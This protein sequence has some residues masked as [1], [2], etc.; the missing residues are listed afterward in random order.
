MPAAG[1]VGT[2]GGEV[3]SC[4]ARGGSRQDWIPSGTQLNGLNDS[5]FDVLDLRQLSSSRVGSGSGPLPA[6]LM[7]GGLLNSVN[8]ARARACRPTVEA[9]WSGRSPEYYLVNSLY[10]LSQIQSATLLQLDTQ[11]RLGAPGQLDLSHPPRPRAFPAH[12][13]PTHPLSLSDVPLAPVNLPRATPIELLVNARQLLTLTR[14]CW[15]L[16]KPSTIPLVAPYPSLS[17]TRLTSMWLGVIQLAHATATLQQGT[18]DFARLNK[19]VA[20]RRVRP[21]RPR[22]GPRVRSLGLVY[23]PDAPSQ[24]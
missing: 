13:T 4:R 5:P 24:S 9:N 20:S 23:K 3:E 15:K 6:K 2:G 22:L 17:H 14:P 21:T 1:P 11:L 7:G 19:V 12:T 16:G 10:K 18:F 8:R